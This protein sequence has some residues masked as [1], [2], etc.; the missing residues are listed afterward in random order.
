MMM[1]QGIPCLERRETWGTRLP[2][3]SQSARKKDEAPRL[4]K[5][6]GPSTSLGMTDAG[7]V[8]VQLKSCPSREHEITRIVGDAGRGEA[9]FVLCVRNEGWRVIDESGEDDLYPEEYFVFV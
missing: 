1:E 4:A 8:R 5:T 9:G 2:P 7:W 6:Q 3:F